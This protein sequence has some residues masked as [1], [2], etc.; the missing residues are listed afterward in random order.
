MVTS[1]SSNYSASAEHYVSNA[2]GTGGF[3][4]VQA[5]VTQPGACFAG[6]AG[7]SWV[8][9]WQSVAAL[10]HRKLSLPRAVLSSLLQALA[11]SVLAWAVTTPGWLLLALQALVTQ[12]E[13]RSGVMSGLG[14]R[15]TTERHANS[16]PSMAPQQQRLGLAGAQQTAF[17]RLASTLTGCAQ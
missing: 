12:G 3:A 1:L 11:V 16:A 8:Q 9:L 14:V 13:G 5:C 17:P 4:S 6:L 2:D 10:T 15:A 7:C